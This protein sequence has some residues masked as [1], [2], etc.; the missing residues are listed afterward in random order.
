MRGVFTFEPSFHGIPPKLLVLGWVNRPD[1]PRNRSSQAERGGEPALYGFLGLKRVHDHFVYALIANQFP[2]E[3]RH[4]VDIAAEDACRFVFLQ[5]NSVTI[6][7]DF[8]PILFADSQ[9]PAQFDWNNHPAKFV[10]FPYN[11]NAFHHE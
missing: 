3:I 10:H 4:L 7:I 2:L 11:P 8:K 6:D 9:R 1:Q 5:H